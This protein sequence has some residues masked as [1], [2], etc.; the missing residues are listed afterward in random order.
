MTRA[1]G[2]LRDYGVVTAAYWVFTLTDGALRTLV[3]FHLHGLGYTP[4][5]V[6]SLFLFY[7]L[8]GVVT[9]AVGGWLGARFGLRS[10]LVSGLSLQVVACGALALLAGHLS[11]P[12]VLAAQA[13]SGIA[14]DLTKMSAKSWVKL[15]VPASDGR[16]LLKWVAVLTGSKNALKGV[17]LLLGGVLLET[18]GFRAANAGMAV[19]LV[20]ALAA[21][22]ALLP[23]ASGR[24]A[25]KV[26]LGQLVARDA[27]VIW[28]S[29]A[30][31]FLFASRDAW[32]VFALPIFLSASLGWSYARSSGFLAAWVIGY[33]VV[34]ALAPGWVGARSSSA[35]RAPGAG[36]VMAWTGLL[37]VPL[38]ALAATLALDVAPAVSLVVGL[39]AFGVV[40]ATDSAVH[41]FLVVHYAEGER[42]SLNVGFYYMANAAGRL[43]GTVLSGAVFQA[44]G[45]G[46]NGLVAC[47]GASI[48]LVGA[49]F[50]LCLPLRAAEARH[51]RASVGA[52]DAGPAA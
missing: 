47:L 43:V 16:G 49:S 52:G 11:V 36:S 34:Q 41:S 7:E 21:S 45:E 24:A 30:R 15:V 32:F 44:A 17:G 20:A 4:V 5:E 33:G 40:F 51:A 38:G 22:R 46:T 42:V 39:A 14:K 29:A 35:R 31:L 12:V 25:S 27:R 6:V 8:F 9:N 19:T 18:V 37:V 28:L 3:L 26:S 1:R 10:T 23:A 50:V 13:L 48:A 2:S